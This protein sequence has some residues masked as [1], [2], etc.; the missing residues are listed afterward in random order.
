MQ[1]VQKCSLTV[2]LMKEGNVGAGGADGA[3]GG[4]GG[5]HVYC[6]FGI[7]SS[8]SVGWTNHVVRKTTPRSIQVHQLDD[9]LS[10]QS[11]IDFP[12]GSSGRDPQHGISPR[13]ASE[14]RCSKNE[15]A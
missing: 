9:R 2:L 5:V 4:D 13:R 7:A 8:C 11:R 3:S 10:L 14:C 1:S 12:V 6:N 15:K